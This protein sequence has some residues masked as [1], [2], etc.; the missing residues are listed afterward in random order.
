MGPVGAQPESPRA[1]WM[2]TMLIRSVSARNRPPPA[3]SMI[4]TPGTSCHEPS[5]PGIRL[6]N[7]ETTRS[8]STV[9]QSSG[10]VPVVEAD[11]AV[12]QELGDRVDAL[13]PPPRRIDERGVI[14]EEGGQRFPALLV[15][16]DLLP[17]LQVP[18]VGVEGFSLS[19]GVVGHGS[20]PI[21]ARRDPTGDDA[22]T[23]APNAATMVRCPLDV[24]AG[25]LE[26]ADATS[27]LPCSALRSHSSWSPSSSP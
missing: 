22:A 25:S 20:S 2:C 9:V 19:L 12:V 23:R 24:N 10:K 17:R 16:V 26:S 27:S 18:L 5:A 11:H 7:I 4:E 6:R 21:D 13:D 1:S 8:P 14:G 3:Y 15:G